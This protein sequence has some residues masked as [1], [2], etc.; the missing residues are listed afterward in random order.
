MN[1]MQPISVL[2]LNSSNFKKKTSYK[3][4]EIIESLN[5]NKV[6]KEKNT[7]SVPSCKNFVFLC[8]NSD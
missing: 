3:T 5:G 2:F 4:N 8:L 6:K 7:Y 1:I